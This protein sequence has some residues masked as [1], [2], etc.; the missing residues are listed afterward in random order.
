M[1]DHKSSLCN[2]LCI[3]MDKVYLPHQ[4]ECMTTWHLFALFGACGERGAG[5]GGGGSKSGDW[6]EGLESLIGFLPDSISD[7]TCNAHFYLWCDCTLRNEK[8]DKFHPSVCSAPKLISSN[9]LFFRGGV[10]SHFMP[11]FDR[12]KNNFKL[13][14]RLLW[15]AVG[16]TF[17]YYYSIISCKN[18]NSHFC[19]NRNYYIIFSHLYNP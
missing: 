11:S 3:I 10:T 8:G 16:K 13:S 12:P 14:L 1:V 7:F 6:M 17:F 15:R 19:I 2:F 9:S 4:L 5:L 18:F